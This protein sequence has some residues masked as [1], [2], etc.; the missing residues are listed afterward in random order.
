MSI[1]FKTYNR[2][3]QLHLY[4]ETWVF[5]TKVQLDEVLGLFPKKEIS[6]AE[7][8][9]VNETIEVTFN[10]LIM[11]CRDLADLKKKFGLLAD[12]KERYQKQMV[13]KP[14]K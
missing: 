12:L 14:K 9:P 13:Q 11:D 8:K 1:V 2:K 4:Q 3:H 5:T 10:G 7:I 6:K